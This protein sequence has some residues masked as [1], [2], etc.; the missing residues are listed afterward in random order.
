M[1]AGFDIH[2]LQNHLKW[3][4]QIF[5]CGIPLVQMSSTLQLKLEPNGFGY[6]QISVEN[7]YYTI[8]ELGPISLRKGSLY[9]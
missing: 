4:A 7:I 6:L 1:D 9:R 8:E 2:L 5:R 3:I